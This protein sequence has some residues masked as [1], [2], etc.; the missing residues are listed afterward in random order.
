VS[1]AGGLLLARTLRVTGMDRGLSAGLARWRQPRAVHDPGKIVAD[2]VM[3]LALGGDCLADVAVLRAQP[4]LFGPVASDPVV[5]RLISRLADDLPAALKTI[6]AARASARQRA[7]ALAGGTGPAAGGGLVPLD[8]DATV[9]AAAL[10]T[11][12]SSCR[13]ELAQGV[14]D[15]VLASV[16]ANGRS[17][18]PQIRL[19][20]AAVRDPREQACPTTAD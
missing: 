3:T 1:Q 14:S 17:G 9:V 15:L 8:V 13:A 4:Q 20:Q 18:Q 12:S 5:S 10:R 2:L 6:R 11:G 16:V 19:D 7:W